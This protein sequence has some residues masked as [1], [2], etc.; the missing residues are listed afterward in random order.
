MTI[1]PGMQTEAAKMAAQTA[2]T[3]ANKNE[4]GTNSSI[5]AQPQASATDTVTISGKATNSTPASTAAT[6]TVTISMEAKKAAQEASE[7]HAQTAKEAMSGDLQ[8]Q[9][10]LAK[11][12]A[13]EEGTEPS[14]VKSQEAAGIRE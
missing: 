6:D 4:A 5:S 8:A 9:R 14:S 11:Q 3:N 10:K 13:A 1:H 12:A 7:T 2:V